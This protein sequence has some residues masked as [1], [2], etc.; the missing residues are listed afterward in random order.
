MKNGAKKSDF[1]VR[2]IDMRHTSICIFFVL[3]NKTENMQ[4]SKL[5]QLL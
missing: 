1:L 5:V 4:S 2:K 3:L